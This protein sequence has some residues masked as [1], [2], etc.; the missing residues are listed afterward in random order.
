MNKKE[1]K[2][3]CCPMFSHK[4]YLTTLEF[5][6]GKILGLTRLL[7]D[8]E[9]AYLFWDGHKIILSKV[10]TAHFCLFISYP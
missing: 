8:L 3:S 5:D 1:V 10:M 6:R 2:S 4:L 7:S 9:S